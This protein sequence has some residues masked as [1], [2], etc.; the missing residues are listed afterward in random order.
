MWALALV[1]C[2]LAVPEV[3]WLPGAPKPLS[4]TSLVDAGEDGVLGV[5]VQGT[6]LVTWDLETGKRKLAARLPAE[7]W[8]TLSVAPRTAGESE[9]AVVAA[10]RRIVLVHLRTGR[11]IG[12]WKVPPAVALR[13]IAWAPDGTRLGLVGWELP[14]LRTEGL[15]ADRGTPVLWV[16]AETGTVVSQLRMPE[17]AEAINGMASLADGR[18]VALGTPKRIVVL[19]PGPNDARTIGID[20]E[21]VVGATREGIVVVKRGLLVVVDPGSGKTAKE[22]SRLRAAIELTAETRLRS[23]GHWAVATARGAVLAIDLARGRVITLS[24]ALLGPNAVVVPGLNGVIVLGKKVL[25]LDLTSS[26]PASLMLKQMCVRGDCRSGEG[27]LQDLVTNRLYTGDF[28]AGEA[29]GQGILRYEDG[30]IYTGPFLR[31]KP[32]G[33]GRLLTPVGDERKVRAVNGELLPV[34]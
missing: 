30:A 4:A 20:N 34:Q 28:R 32:H 3:D 13:D 14:G 10:E 33:L 18:S 1:A 29:S 7:T 16:D 24:Q 5:S 23:G 12:D 2:L 27:A 25:R 11:L 31:G 8:H 15:I 19:G 6:S 21:G 22:L 17:M 9:R 26:A